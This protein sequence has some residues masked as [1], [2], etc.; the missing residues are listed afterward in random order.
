LPP[1]ILLSSVNGQEY[2]LKVLFWITNIRQEQLTKSEILAGI[3]RH[4]PALHG[5][6]LAA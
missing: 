5:R 3:Y 1:E 6:G 4:L 2:E